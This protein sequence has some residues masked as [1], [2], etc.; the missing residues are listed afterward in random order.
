MT[1]KFTLLPLAIL[2]LYFNLAPAQNA[3]KTGS[4][5]VEPSTLI[6]LGFE[7]YITGDSNR[8]AS[9]AVTYRPAGTA[10]WLN[11]LPLMRMGDERVIRETEFMDYTVPHQFAG[12]ILDLNPDAEYECRFVMS[13]PDGV[14]GDSVQLVKVRTRREPTAAKGGRTLHVYPVDW[15]GAM[16]QPAFRGLKAAYYGSGLGDWSV[17]SERKVQPGD[18]ILVHAGMYKADRLNYVEPNGL[19]FDGTYVLTAKGTEEKPI[20]IKGAG[21]GEVI[22]DGAGAHHFFDVTA[23]RHHIF[24]GLT[25]RNADVAFIA[26]QKEVAGASDLTIRNCRI[27]DVGIAIT[28]EFAGSKNFYIADNVIIGRDDRYR[29]RGWANPGV[30]PPNQ[31]NSYMA[32]RVYGSGHVICFN[33]VA[34][35]HDGIDVS[36]YGT[37]EKEQDLKAVAIDIYNNDIHLVADDFIESDGGVHNIRVMRNR[38]VNAGQCGLSA[39]PIFGGPAYFIRNI[40]YNVPNGCALKFMSKPAGLYVFHNT[41]IAENGN[42]QT[43]SN[44]HFRNNLFLGIDAAK[45]AVAVFPMATSYSTYDYDG[46]RPNKK[47]GDQFVWIAPEGKSRDYDITA[48]DAKGFA[49]L[50]EFSA[51]TGLETHGVEIDYDIFENLAPP[52]PSTP[53]AVYHAAD[54]DFRIKPNSRAVDKGIVLPNVNDG[55]KGKAP[56]LGAIEAGTPVPV[57]GRRIADKHSFYR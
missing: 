5:I 56:D 41:I 30:Y 25:I 9:V 31:L 24:E 46:Y 36:T 44:A 40:L 7:W 11:A 19:S 52:D 33:D 47:G 20:V 6:N 39:Q 21:D 13:D 14:Q 2:T 27:E 55:F 51:A 35:F 23:T 29:V 37:P 28:T 54:L 3:V 18:V 32:I 42:R 38:G 10:K 26:G 17:V 4:F 16:Q 48:K 45:R 1:M 12:S 50:K 8:N 22:F 43:Y 15:N 53:H 34:F 57:Y 49:S